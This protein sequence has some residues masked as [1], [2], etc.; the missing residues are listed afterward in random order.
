MAGEGGI[1]P[2]RLVFDVSGPTGADV[3]SQMAARLE[4]AGVVSDGASLARALRERE[5]RSSTALG[6]GIAIPHGK[7]PG[8]RGVVVALGIAR[9]PVAFGAAD[10]APVDLVFLL[11]SPAEAPPTHLQALSR[12]SRILRVP[13][14]AARIRQAGS[15]AAAEVLREA[16][17]GLMVASG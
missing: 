15:G 5:R 4:E 11:L 10:S 12:L 7:V 2:A 14:T 13:G 6:S 17:A 16:E 1:V 8:L 3:L 9:P